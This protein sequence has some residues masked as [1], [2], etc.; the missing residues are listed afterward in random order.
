MKPVAKY[1]IFTP[2]SGKWGITFTVD[3]NAY[4]EEIREFITEL[5]PTIEINGITLPRVIAVD[6][7]GSGGGTNPHCYVWYWDFE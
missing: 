6:H 2:D 5:G 1:K 7:R 4:A 3:Y